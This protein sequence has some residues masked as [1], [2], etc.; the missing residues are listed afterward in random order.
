MFLFFTSLEE[1][2]LQHSC[3]H[4]CALIITFTQNALLLLLFTNVLINFQGT[5]QMTQAHEV[6]SK[7]LVSYLT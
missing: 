7:P 6:F 4:I 5:D 1:N 2:C 3:I